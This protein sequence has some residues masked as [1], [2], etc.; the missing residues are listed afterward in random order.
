MSGHI[1]VVKADGAALVVR[2]GAEPL[3]P[4]RKIIE[5]KRQ[6]HVV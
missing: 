3:L 4:Q 6:V 1:S 2:P 5:R